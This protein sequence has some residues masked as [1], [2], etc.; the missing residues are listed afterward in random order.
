MLAHLAIFR[1]PNIAKTHLKLAEFL[2]NPN[3]KYLDTANQAIAYCLG[4]K[5][6]AIKYSSKVYRAH[7]YFKN[8]KGEDITFYGASNTAFVDYKDTR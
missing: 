1:R 3:Q 7:I 4:T 8:P 2:T 5:S 6:T